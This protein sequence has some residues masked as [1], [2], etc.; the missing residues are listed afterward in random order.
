MPLSDEV[1]AWVTLARAPALDAETL[2]T[3]LERLGSAGGIMA[4]SDAARECCG[5]PAPA[6]EYLRR[7]AFP[8]AAERKWLEHARHH[9]LPFT[10]PRYPR[11]LRSFAHRPLA[12]YAAGNIDA[13][14][15]PQLAVVGSRNPTPQGRDTAY[16]FSQYLA[17]RGLAITS[18]LAHGIDTCAHRGALAAQGITLAVLGCGLDVVY[19]RSNYELSEA[20]ELQGALISEFPLGSAP[21][22]AHF[23][24][25]NRIIAGLSLGTL[26]VEAAHG[27]GS[28]ITARAANERGREVFAVPGSIHNPLSRG[29]HELIKDGRKT[30]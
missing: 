22:R 15:D 4:A 7:A 11:L 5:I 23:P 8:G 30:D 3:A 1:L 26:V 27:S 10:D 16:E 12:L 2:S 13:L 18:G 25:R 29:C 9:V 19:P 21:L 6:R 17:E 20:I 24:Q 14:S 28:L